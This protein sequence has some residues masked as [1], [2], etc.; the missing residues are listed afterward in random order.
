MLNIP[1][2]ITGKANIYV[3]DG[4]LYVKIK[5]VLGAEDSLYL[6]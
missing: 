6:E 4:T 2:R 1:D 5:K 3:K